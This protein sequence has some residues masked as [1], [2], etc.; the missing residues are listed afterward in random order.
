MYTFP[1]KL[2]L[3]ESD[4][5]DLGPQK[6]MLYLA[7]EHTL[8]VTVEKMPG[9]TIQRHNKCQAALMLVRRP[10]PSCPCHSR[11]QHEQVSHPKRQEE[12]GKVEWEQDI[13]GNGGDWYGK[14]V[15]GSGS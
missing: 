5:M 7:V 11:H 8:Q 10:E 4:E 6:L 15:G 12:S 2:S 3:H 1:L 13:L 14:A 9:S